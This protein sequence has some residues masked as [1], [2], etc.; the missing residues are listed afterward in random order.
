MFNLCER[1]IW[2]DVSPILVSHAIMA[3]KQA[4]RQACAGP[5]PM[6]PHG[7]S[8]TINCNS[9]VL[10]PNIRHPEMLLVVFTAPTKT[11]FLLTDL[12]LRAPEMFLTPLMLF[13]VGVL[14]L[15]SE[16]PFA[17]LQRPSAAAAVART[18]GSDSSDPSKQVLR[19]LPGGLLQTKCDMLCK[20]TKF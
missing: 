17:F 15:L 16:S 7:C 11:Q 9:V 14:S 19:T 3:P 2:L 1:V 6:Q 5:Q 18:P 8:T 13:V 10:T 20:R 12:L 4:H